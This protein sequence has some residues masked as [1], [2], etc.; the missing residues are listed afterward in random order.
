MEG[1][2]KADSAGAAEET[3][4]QRGW[5][6]ADRRPEVLAD[7]R[8]GRLGCIRSAE[9]ALAGASTHWAINYMARERCAFTPFADIQHAGIV[10]ALA[11]AEKRIVKTLVRRGRSMAE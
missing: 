6:K 8:L 9:P 3:N 1:A 5:Q 10:G 4:A 2:A 7:D 11:V